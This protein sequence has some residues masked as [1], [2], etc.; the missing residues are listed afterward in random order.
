M[1]VIDFGMTVVQAWL[2]CAVTVIDF[3]MTMV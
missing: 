1:T 3:S 2:H